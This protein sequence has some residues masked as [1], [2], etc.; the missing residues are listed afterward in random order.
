VAAEVPARV[1]R[2][3]APAA[4]PQLEPA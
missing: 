4:A 2:T 1:P 3:P